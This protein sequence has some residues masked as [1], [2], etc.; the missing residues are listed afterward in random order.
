[1]LIV[2]RSL[3]DTDPLLQ[4]LTRPFDSAGCINSQPPLIRIWTLNMMLCVIECSALYVLRTLDTTVRWVKR[5]SD[6]RPYP[7][8][9]HFLLEVPSSFLTTPTLH[10]LP[11]I[12]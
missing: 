2:S 5:L 4:L 6:A 3:H 1:M 10:E 11:I 8:Y 12:V 7:T 9:P